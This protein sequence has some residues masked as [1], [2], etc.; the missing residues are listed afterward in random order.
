MPE[1]IPLL[2]LKPIPKNTC[3]YDTVP[4]KVFYGGNTAFVWNFEA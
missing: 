1:R 4:Y 3:W 2:E